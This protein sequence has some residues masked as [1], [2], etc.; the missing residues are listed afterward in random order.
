MNNNNELPSLTLTPSNPGSDLNDNA[1]QVSLDETQLNE[2]ERKIVEDFSKRIDLTDSM[3]IMKYGS[4]AQQKV[5]DFSDTALQNVKT[6]DLGEVGGMIIN[7][8]NELSQVNI[9][10]GRKGIGGLFKRSQNKLN[11]IKNK[12][13]KAEISVEKICESLETHQQKLLKDISV[14]D[15]LYIVN[16]SN[17]KEITLYIIA[18]KKRL[19][20]ARETTLKEL[21]ARAAQS[22]L[23]ED[24]QSANDFAALCDRFEKKIYDLEL[25]RMVAI[26]SAPQI[27]LIQNNDTLLAE[28]IQSTIVNT[29]PLWKSQMIIALGL[30]HAQDAL[31][32]QR[33]VTDMTNE[34][35]K[36]NASALKLGTVETAREAERGV[37]DIE[38]LVYTNQTLIETLDEVLKINEE[39]RAKRRAAETELNRMEGQLKSKLL[40][41]NANNNN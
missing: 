36:R 32:A 31:T 16:L 3:M 13:D 14:L 22:K 41:I 19:K 25:T 17:F 21:L 12:Y 24:A 27:R 28:K 35:L 29:I 20:E 10:E 8:V 6:K 26:Q 2:Q 23:S 5:A 37:V 30:A 11:Q 38:T 39:G 40:E 15:K 1:L 34:L 18:G 7:L 9:E 33:Q 4:L